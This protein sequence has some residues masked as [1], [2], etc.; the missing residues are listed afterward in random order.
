M[1]PAGGDEEGAKRAM[2]RAHSVTALVAVSVVLVSC[3]GDRRLER[4]AAAAEADLKAALEELADVAAERQRRGEPPGG[5]AG[6]AFLERMTAA[7][8]KY[9]KERE[10]RLKNQEVKGPEELRRLYFLDTAPKETAPPT[11]EEMRSVEEARLV[12]AQAIEELEKTHAELIAKLEA[13]Q[14][15][16][17]EVWEK[18]W[19]GQRITSANMA[20]RMT[21]GLI[22]E[23]LAGDRLGAVEQAIVDARRGRVGVEEDIEAAEEELESLN[24]GGG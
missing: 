22:N 17:E 10:E 4:R 8:E 7:N 11:G 24:D 18:R 14:E 2:K 23:R 21:L 6:K 1:G 5:P 3:G 13:I 20:Q 16:K 15:A 19:L 12:A 9:M